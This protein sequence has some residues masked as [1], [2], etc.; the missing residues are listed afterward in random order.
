MSPSVPA[1]FRLVS[2]APSSHVVPDHDLEDREDTP[3]SPAERSTQ[4]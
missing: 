3:S 4:R 1:Q 2:L